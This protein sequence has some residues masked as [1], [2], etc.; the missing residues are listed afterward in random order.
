[1]KRYLLNAGLLVSLALLGG[2]CAPQGEPP[3]KPAPPARSEIPEALKPRIDA[4]LEDVHNRDLRTTNGFWT[5]FH[6]ILGMGPA[7]TLYDPETKKR[8]NALDEIC[9]G[10]KIR[11]MEFVKT[12]QGVDVVTMLGT[13]VGQGHQDQFIAEMAQWDMPRKRKFIVAGKNYTFEDFI[14]QSKMHASLTKNQELSWAVLIV[15]Q[16]FG[17]DHRWTNAFGEPLTLEDVVRYEVNQSIDTAA[18]GGTHRLFGLTWAYHLHRVK[19]GKQEGVWREVA[20]K[21]EHYKDN[22]LKYQNGDGSFS[23]AYLSKPGQAPDPQTRIATT[24]HVL[25]WLALAMTDEELRSEKMQQAASALA[26]MILANQNNPLD[27]G[28]LY[29]ATHGLHIYQTRVFG[30]PPPAGLLIPR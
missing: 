13:G 30:T 28:A 15:A 8:V 26:V 21:I 11:G 17:T 16:Y 18:C 14:R 20:N 1:M 25:E 23:A 2:S 7:T 22:A 19:G 3:A 6:G 10:A 24:G 27:G 29:H 12:D 9:R 5:I 4:A